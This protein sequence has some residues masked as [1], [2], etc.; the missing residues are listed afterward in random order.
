M[1]AFLTRLAAGPRVTSGLAVLAL[2]GGCHRHADT[3]AIADTVR[4]NIAA[5]VA[6]FNAH[7]PRRIIAND[8][9]EWVS[10]IHGTPNA[11]G[12]QQ[13]LI[14]ARQEAAVPAARLVIG[15]ITVDVAAA[16]DLATSRTSYAYT[17]TDAKT[18]FSYIERG[19]WVQ[20]WKRQADGSWK[21]AW[22]IFAD[23]PS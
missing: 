3:A 5:T 2:L 9:P 10:M 22:Q 6:G 15:D 1:I 19:N 12:L 4:A 18:G 21:A 20:E 7:D 13:D 23:A 16:G 14:Q 11:T 17:H 8:A